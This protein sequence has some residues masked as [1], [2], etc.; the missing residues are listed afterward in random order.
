MASPV[1][2]LLKGDI[3]NITR[4]HNASTIPILPDASLRRSAEKQKKKTE[5]QA[6]HE[7]SIHQAVSVRFVSRTICTL[8]YRRS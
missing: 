5:T 6:I 2:S 1:A 3:P 7:I 8:S 4:S